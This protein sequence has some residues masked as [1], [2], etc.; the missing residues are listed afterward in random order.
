MKIYL[1]TFYAV[2]IDKGLIKFIIY[3]ISI[4]INIKSI[5]YSNVLVFLK[6][7]KVKYMKKYRLKIRYFLFRFKTISILL[8]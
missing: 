8:W 1:T 5:F 4:H 2:N 6:I 7:Y 3:L